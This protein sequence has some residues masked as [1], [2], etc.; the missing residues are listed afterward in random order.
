M[1][2]R[3]GEWPAITRPVSRIS[4]G[5]R[6]NHIMRHFAGMLAAA[7]LAFGFDLAASGPARAW[8]D[9]GHEVIALIAQSFLEP[10]VREKV[11]ALLASDPDSLTPHTIA[12][13]ATWADKYRDADVNG[14][15]QATRL[16]HFVDIELTAPD[17]DNACFGHPRLPPGRPASN[18]PAQDCVIDKINEFEA[19]LA[20]PATDAAE[21]IVALKFLLHLVGDEHQPLHAS[22][23]HDSGGNRKH[24]SAPG[25]PS[26]TLHHYWD[27]E[28]VDQLGPDE[29]R[30]AETLTTHISGGDVRAW[31]RGTPADWAMESFRLAKDDA[32]GGLPPPNARG[33]YRLTDTYVATARRDV[34]MQLSK[35]GVRLARILNRAMG[36]GR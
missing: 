3:A 2:L 11:T 19:E 12:A 25:M 31:S 17:I 26:G 5:A 6:R 27:T 4:E 14:A 23:D 1:R 35:A 34:A 13:E 24:V 29:R 16:W 21:R 18:G 30:I 28:F 8:G 36:S 15:R 20:S 32:Y 22:D 10:A 9:E 7:T 33:S